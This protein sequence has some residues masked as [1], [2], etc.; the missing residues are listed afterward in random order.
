MI[1]EKELE[2]AIDLCLEKKLL[3]ACYSLPQQN[4]CD[5]IIQKDASIKSFS[6]DKFISKDMG[7]VFCPFDLDSSYPKVFIH[8]DYHGK[9]DDIDFEKLENNNKGLIEKTS[10]LSP[11]PKEDY[12]LKLGELIGEIK[13][14]SELKKV[15]FSRIQTIDRSKDFKESRSFISLVKKYPEAFTSIVN[16]PGIGCWLGATPETLVKLKNQ[17]VFTMALAGTQKNIP[18]TV[19]EVNWSE[20]DREEQLFVS[21]FIEQNLKSNGVLTYKKQGPQT[22]NAAQVKHLLT[23]YQFDYKQLQNGVG[24]FIKDMH[25]TPAVGGV[26]KEKAL[27]WIKRL[28]PHCREY[29][30]GFLGPVNTERDSNLFVNL[31][32]MKVGEKNLALYIG[33]G[34]TANSKV[35]KEW[36]ETCL[37]SQTLLS[38]L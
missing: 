3:F 21:D 23:T 8:A 36:E 2:K 25:P 27:Q 13:Q 19:A 22:L 11:M 5:F 20:K 37:K 30:S 35:E 4:L 18:G 32:C 9:V 24:N 16:I 28:E 1:F 26:P 31:R 14:D 34:I 15:V 12:Y 7:F 6:F 33:G 29:Y 17:K 10:E 38:I